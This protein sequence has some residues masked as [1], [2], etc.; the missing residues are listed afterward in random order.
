MT[1]PPA[2]TRTAAGRPQ[3]EPG[4][5]AAAPRLPA[6]EATRALA[7]GLAA[8]VAQWARALGAD[9]AAQRAAAAA[10][11][12]L[13]LATSQGHV[14]LPLDELGAWPGPPA[15]RSAPE[16]A[17]GA[18]ALRAA[19]LRS[20]VVA[21]WPAAG[22]QALPLVLDGDGRLYLHR[23]FE[24]ERRLALRLARAAAAGAATTP[25]P[26]ALRRLRELFPPPAAGAAP[27]RQA[28][29]VA[30]ALRRPL[31][32]VSGGPGTGKTTTLVALLSCLLADR[33]DLRVA[34]AAPTGK[35]AARMTQALAERTAGWPPEWQAVLPRQAGTVHR[36][37]GARPQGPWRHH[38]GHPLPLDLLVVDEASMLD[39]ALAT[40][41]LCAVPEGARI[42]LLG[43]K[44]QLA[45]VEAGAVFAEIGADPR[46]GGPLRAALAA[47]LG[48]PPQALQELQEMQQP[49]DAAPPLPGSAA[50]QPAGAAAESLPGDAAGLAAEDQVATAAAGPGAASAAAAGA[51]QRAAP[52]LP[53]ACVW[54]TRNHRFAA[55]SGIGRLALAVRDGQA[56]AALQALRS[57][58]P[59]LRWRPD[60]AAQPA[61]ATWA[62]LEQGHEPYAQAVGAWLAG[63]RP[64]SAA[65][66]APGAAAA[67]TAAGAGSPAAL[68]AALDGL[69]VLCPLREGPRGVAAADARLAAWL[70]RRLAAQDLDTGPAGSPWFPGRPVMVLRNDAALG[71]S[72]GD[73]GI[74]LPDPAAA[75][76]AGASDPAALLVWFPDG[77]GGWRRIAPARLPPHQGGFA[78]TVHKAQGSEFGAVALLLPQRAAPVLTRE[79][80]YTAVTRA[81]RHVL[82]VGGAEVLAAAIATPTR[83][84]S[85]LAARLREL[86]ATAGGSCR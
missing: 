28:L 11:H 64:R 21:T 53:D 31:V 4:S 46:L 70:R 22:R 32:V 69:R 7:E 48:L 44:D 68:F 58:D 80:V 73:V 61:A 85:G 1:A 6:D 30:L 67:A 3:G 19:L 2:G 25:G 59:A 26:A 10:A 12:A 37:L 40:R 66:Q 5:A 57:A 51:A 60:A 14:C 42:V 72:N 38:A 20:R 81:R 8:H 35:A 45:A 83:R 84:R 15:S 34:L 9:A 86:A 74:A 39:L 17:T 54:F 24:L 36:L 43:D 52:A 82:V 16:A 56:G 47:D 63:A 13:S 41:L 77:R 71:V 79:L 18:G 27:D 55:G 50:A 75:G 29:A 76:A 23:H 78:L 49:Q 62:A 33:P 65:P